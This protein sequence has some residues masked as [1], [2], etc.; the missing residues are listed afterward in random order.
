MIEYNTH[1]TE[2]IPFRCAVEAALRRDQQSSL[3]YLQHLEEQIE[4]LESDKRDLEEKLALTQELRRK[5]LDNI[6]EVAEYLN[7]HFGEGLSYALTPPNIPI[8]V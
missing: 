1:Q 5:Y 3:H 4:E 6:S 7:R 8:M 2:S